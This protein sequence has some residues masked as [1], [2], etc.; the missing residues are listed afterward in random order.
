MRASPYILLEAAMLIQ[1]MN[2]QHAPDQFQRE[3]CFPQYWPSFNKITDPRYLYLLSHFIQK[4][5]LAGKM[6]HNLRIVRVF[7]NVFVELF[8][9]HMKDSLPPSV[10][11]DI[12]ALMEVRSSINFALYTNLISLL[13]LVWTSLHGLGWHSREAIY[14]TQSRDMQE[15]CARIVE[16][17]GAFHETQA[18]DFDF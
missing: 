10:L 8:W 9:R 13:M 18:A 14:G 16:K 2:Q 7:Y 15:A 12:L 5:E 6:Q 1:S 4:Q 17:I 11:D 3:V